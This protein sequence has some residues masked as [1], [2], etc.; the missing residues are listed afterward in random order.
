MDGKHWGK[1]SK[2][3]ITERKE[4]KYENSYVNARPH[5][6]LTLRI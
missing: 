1:K 2:R 6:N 3:G 5:I 4:V